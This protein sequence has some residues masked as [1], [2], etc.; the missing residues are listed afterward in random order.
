MKFIPTHLLDTR[1]YRRYSDRAKALLVDLYRAADNAGFAAFDADKLAF[2]GNCTEDALRAAVSELQDEVKI[3]DHKAWLRGFLAG[4]YGMAALRTRHDPTM[5]G[6][7]A[8]LEQHADEFPEVGELLA[9]M[10]GGADVSGKEPTIPDNGAESEMVNPPRTRHEPRITQQQVD[11]IY[12][13]Y[14]RKVGKQ[15]AVQAIRK[16]MEAV[17][18]EALLEATSAYCATVA[19]WSME[20]RKFIPHPATWFRAGRYD[21]DR[22]EWV[23]GNGKQVRPLDVAERTRRVLEDN[24]GK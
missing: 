10:G 5:Q 19:G 24:A 15:A 22:R 13:A 16:A 6:I 1:T 2:L 12:A 23:R 8:L 21:D 18:Y 9:R 11:A 20:D 3:C 14:P 7:W 17:G 4:N